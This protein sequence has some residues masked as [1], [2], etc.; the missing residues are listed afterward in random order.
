MIIKLSGGLDR[1]LM[2]APVL[3]EYKFRNPYEKI[4]FETDYPLFTCEEADK[5][6]VFIDRKDESVLVLDIFNEISE[7][8][9]IMD[10]YASIILGDTR[11]RN[12]MIDNIPY[13]NNL[14]KVASPNIVIDS[15]FVKMVP[16]LEKYGKV[17]VAEYHNSGLDN[18]LFIGYDDDLSYLA[19]TSNTPMI[20]IFDKRSPKYVRPFRKNIFFEAI[21]PSYEVC[22]SAPFCLRKNGLIEF[23]NVYGVKCDNETPF[24]CENYVTY[25]MVMESVKRILHEC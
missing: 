12:R 10:L 9:H 5:A 22:S 8:M 1:V 14:R 18:I 7:D 15:R 2:L 11:I 17:E 25:E 24:A 20:M 23:K 4:Y 13:L 16:D 21:E 19:M 3:R 6:A